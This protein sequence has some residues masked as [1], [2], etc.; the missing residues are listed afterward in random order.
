MTDVEHKKVSVVGLEEM[1]A[2]RRAANPSEQLQTVYSKMMVHK[3]IGKI[4][5]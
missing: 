3:S 2:I 4:W 5:P 1:K